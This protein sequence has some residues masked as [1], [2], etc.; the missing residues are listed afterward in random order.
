MSNK[1]FSLADFIIS[2]IEAVHE[3]H[4]TK[5]RHQI[6]LEHHKLSGKSPEDTSP[7][8]I[9]YRRFSAIYPLD[10]HSFIE[11]FMA[12]PLHESL[13]PTLK[14]MDEL[15]AKFAYD[16]DK[17]KN[18]ISYVVRYSMSADLVQ[19]YIPQYFLDSFPG[20]YLYPGGENPPELYSTI[21]SKFSEEIPLLKKYFLMVKLH[22]ME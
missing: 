17:L 20:Y 22:E 6:I 10:F 21:E 3:H 5:R 4:E 1:Y 9:K 18:F 2:L 7:Y 16:M 19:K 11:P 8:I 14:E 12:E 13:I 15:H